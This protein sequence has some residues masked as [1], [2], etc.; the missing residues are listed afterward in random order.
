MGNRGNTCTSN[1]QWYTNKIILF[2]I[3]TYSG[4]RKYLV[5]QTEKIGLFQL[6]FGHGKTFDYETIF[7]YLRIYR[8]ETNLETWEIFELIVQSHASTKPFHLFIPE[9]I[10]FAQ[11]TENFS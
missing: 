10:K 9:Q 1:V 4:F 8:P 11:I 2:I 7:L 6:R 3:Q 5:L